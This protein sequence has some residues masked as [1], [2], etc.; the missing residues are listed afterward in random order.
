MRHSFM[1]FSEQKKLKHVYRTHVSIVVF[2]FLSLSGIV[3]CAALFPTYIQ[4]SHDVRD[5][6]KT[7]GDSSAASS[8]SVIQKELETHKKLVAALGQGNETPLSVIASNVIVLRSSV[9]INSIQIDKTGTTSVSI[10]VQGKAP[11][12]ESLVSFKKRLEDSRPGTKVELPI[13]DLTKSKDIS[14]SLKITQ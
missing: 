1:P 10:V 3:G 11:T 4:V 14:Y 13:S 8:I 5:V 2:F 9:S 6:R 7:N 12:R